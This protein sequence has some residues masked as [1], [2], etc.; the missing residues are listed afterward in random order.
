M[1][2]ENASL[3]LAHC[4]IMYLYKELYS[5]TFCSSLQGE[6]NHTVSC[7]SAILE[8]GSL[9]GPCKC[10][11]SNICVK[12]GQKGCF[13]LWEIT[14]Q[15]QVLADKLGQYQCEDRAWRFIIICKEQCTHQPVCTQQGRGTT[16]SHTNQWKTYRWRILFLLKPCTLAHRHLTLRESRGGGRSKYVIQTGSRTVS[17]WQKERTPIPTHTCSSEKDTVNQLVS[18]TIG[19]S[20]LYV[21]L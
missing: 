7:W 4:I 3:K 14:L 1:M 15:R 20:I 11:A 5:S 21:E 17:R 10:K 16:Q 12:S 13:W 8:W 19:E 6:L 18:M 9:R 2:Q